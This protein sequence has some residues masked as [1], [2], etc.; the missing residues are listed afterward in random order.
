M[1]TILE[2]IAN[3]LSAECRDKTQD[4]Q[5][6]SVILTVMIIGII[7]NLVRVAQ[8]C[9]KKKINN[10]EFIK[11]CISRPTWWT[12]MRIKKSIR[13]TIGFE[14]Y[15]QYGAVLLDSILTTGAG[16]TDEQIKQIVETCDA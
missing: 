12:K 6:S 1:N 8:E 4:N 14:K 3:K 16:L 10:A 2:D 7:V 9:N 5:F 13:K 15:K 11:E